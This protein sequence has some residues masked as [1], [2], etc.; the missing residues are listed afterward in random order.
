M[1]DKSTWARLERPA[2]DSWITVSIG[3]VAC[4]QLTVPAVVKLRYGADG[5]QLV[6]HG[7]GC[8]DS[9]TPQPFPEKDNE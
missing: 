7:I 4:P 6:C 5:W 2:T 3:P 9:E 1:N 8:P